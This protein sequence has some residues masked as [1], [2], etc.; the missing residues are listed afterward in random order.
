MKDRAL[1]PT[2]LVGLEDLCADLRLVK[3]PDAGHFITWEKPEAVTR[4]LRAFLGSAI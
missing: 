4:A 2:Q 3:E 1:T